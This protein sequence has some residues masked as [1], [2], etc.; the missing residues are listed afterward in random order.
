VLVSS[1]EDL[2]EA[3]AATINA[4]DVPA[5]AELWIEDATIVAADGTT[6]RGRDAI[7]DALQ[8]LVD[9][10]VKLDIEPGKVFIA[11]DVAVV[12]GTLTLNGT[13]ADGQPFA[14]RSNSVVVYSRGPDGWRIALDA[15]WGFPQ[16]A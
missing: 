11:G 9:N 12:L 14:Q 4:R 8:A 10:G 5:A 6:M 3:F 2:F 15:P 1:P 13:G 7:A 16:G